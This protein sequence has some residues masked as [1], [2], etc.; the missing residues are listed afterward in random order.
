MVSSGVMTRPIA[1]ERAA[2]MLAMIASGVCTPISSSPELATVS[3]AKPDSTVERTLTRASSREP[4]AVATPVM[5]PCGSMA[6]PAAS[7]L[8]P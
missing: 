8:W 7:A 6:I 4:S 2:R 3:T 5:T 1:A